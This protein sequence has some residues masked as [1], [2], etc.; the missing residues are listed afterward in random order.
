MKTTTTLFLALV[1]SG[2]SVYY[3]LLGRPSQDLGTDRNPLKI[4]SLAA[5]DS[6]TWFEIQ[7]TASQEKVALRREGREWRIE[8]PVAYPAE[9]FLVEGMIKALAQGYRLRRIPFRLKDA[10]LLGFDPPR[11]K[12]VLETEK[13]AGRRILLL[14]ADSPVRGRTY[15][16]WEGESEYFLIS[17]EVRAALEMSV[18]S[19]REKK[20]FLNRGTKLDS[21]HLKTAGK[22]FRIE[23]EKETW[24]WAL[25]EPAGEI[26]LEKVSDLIYA[27][28]SLHVK[29]FL[30]GSNPEQEEFG[31]RKKSFFV[32]VG[33]GGEPAQTVVL[34]ERAK[35]KD[36]LYAIRENE[37]LVVLVA[38][39]NLKSLLETF[40]VV[41]QEQKHGDA[42]E[43]EASRGT[44]P[45]SGGKG[46]A[47][48]F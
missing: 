37:H 45:E 31:L 4:I 20:L 40:E 3:F 6:V 47:G 29:E 41:Y 23:K 35:G 33:S 14:G 21:I 48:P 10:K 27:F 26:P 8:L 17:S 24:R 32:T 42:G 36:A 25:P 18:Y 28:E 5:D 12:M 19:L 2:L 46:G 30:D 15:A 38:E 22:E 34:G 43:F 1:L 44:N 39:A 9:E 7:N 16:R 11:L 13:V